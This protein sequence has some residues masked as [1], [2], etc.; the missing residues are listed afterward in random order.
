MSIGSLENQYNQNDFTDNPESQVPFVIM[1]DAV[2]LDGR[3]SHR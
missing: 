1:L 2:P 3:R